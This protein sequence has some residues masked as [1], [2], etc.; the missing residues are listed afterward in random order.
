MVLMQTL[1]ASLQRTD[2]GLGASIGGRS[3]PC[4]GKTNGDSRV[5][6]HGIERRTAVPAVPPGAEP[7]E[8]V[9]LA[10]EPNPAGLAGHNVCAAWL[11]G[12]H[13]G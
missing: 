6:S 12:D 13:G 5:A 4:A 9:E 1:Y 8:V 2:L 3:D 11:A 7:G 10:G